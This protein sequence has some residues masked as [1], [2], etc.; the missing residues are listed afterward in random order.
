MFLWKLIQGIFN[1][2]WWTRVWFSFFR[3][4]TSTALGLTMFL[5]EDEKKEKHTLVVVWFLRMLDGSVSSRSFQ[6]AVNVWWKWEASSKNNANYVSGSVPILFRVGAA[7]SG[8]LVR[9]L[10]I[11]F[12]RN[13]WISPLALFVYWMGKA[14]GRGYLFACLLFC[15]GSSWIA[16]ER[17]EGVATGMKG[18]FCA[19]G[20][21]GVRLFYIITLITFR[22]TAWGVGNEL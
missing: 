21:W 10:F 1:R 20:C 7:G 3:W 19:L 14:L 13:S 15:L 8:Y 17:W 22:G 6:L 9:G 16:A 11:V 4:T 18:V 12:L 5:C 2:G